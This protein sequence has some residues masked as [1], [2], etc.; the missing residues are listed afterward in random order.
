MPIDFPKAGSTSSVNATAPSYPSEDAFEK[1]ERANP[2]L[3]GD[4]DEDDD[5]E[6]EDGSDYDEDETSAMIQAEWEESMRQLEAV[7]SIVLIPFFGK[8]WGRKW[9]FWG[10]SFRFIRAS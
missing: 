9:A 2:L 1:H 8:W 3:A 10:M 7:V 5:E 4:D 6:E